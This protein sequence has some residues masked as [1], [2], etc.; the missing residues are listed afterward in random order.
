MYGEKVSPFPLPLKND[1]IIIERGDCVEKMYRS[2]MLLAFFLEAATPLTISIQPKSVTK[3]QMETD[4]FSVSALGGSGAVHYQWYRNGNLTGSDNA[5]YFTEPLQQNIN[6]TKVW[7]HVKDNSSDICSDT[8]YITVFDTTMSIYGMYGYEEEF[9]HL[10]DSVKSLGIRWERV[11]YN[12][13]IRMSCSTA[14]ASGINPVIQIG[15]QYI[16]Y[17]LTAFKDS[18]TYA[19]QTYGPNGS[20]WKK[21]SY[22]K[23]IPCMY[24]QICN[25]PNGG[26]YIRPSPG[27]TIAKTYFEYLKIAKQVLKTYD[28]RI[29]II[30]M[31][32]AGGM[33]Y[34]SAYWSYIDS[35][36]GT[37]W[38]FIKKVDSLGGLDYM[39]II[40][41]HP[42][43]MNWGKC[44]FMGPEEGGLTEGDDSVKAELAKYGKTGILV[45]HSEVGYALSYPCKEGPPRVTMD[46]LT[47]Q[48]QAD[49]MIRY[50]VIA[51]SDGIINV[52]QMFITDV[53]LDS[54]E[55][56]RKFGMWY[57]VDGSPGRFVP[58][59]QT[60]AIRY[61]S[62]LL[63]NPTSAFIKKL[64]TPDS[65]YAYQFNY[66]PDNGTCIVAWSVKKTDTAQIAISSENKKWSSRGMYGDSLP[67]SNV[68]NTLNIKLTPSPRYF[69]Y[70]MK[71]SNNLIDKRSFNAKKG[72]TPVFFIFNRTPTTSGE[73]AGNV[74]DSRGRKIPVAKT[75]SRG[76][77]V[78]RSP[79]DGI[80]SL[81]PVIR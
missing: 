29:K 70:G 31:N 28:P 1:I 71:Q 40:G 32:T 58:R 65:T 14:A 18:L 25:E 52:N 42:Y 44:R 34:T 56:I 48:Q 55:P 37:W 22:L 61:L 21:H 54:R 75:L 30:G 69:F 76:L 36:S 49:Y 43:G 53:Q 12:S 24:W 35:T 67:L 45:W 77:Y 13:K 26:E 60:A 50:Y 74:F 19:V 11:N 68:N 20:F 72:K 47:E 39:D 5:T 80:V 62:S 79:D 57:W 41:T 8:A 27:L 81:V 4:T 78:I 46:T 7:V 15:D 6:G 10:A 3:Y 63:P 66:G 51:A 16:P 17:T 64:I 38:S 23:P 2:I 9:R 33:R 59:K 73:F